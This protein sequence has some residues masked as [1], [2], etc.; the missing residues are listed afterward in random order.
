MHMKLFK[1]WVT[2]PEECLN[3]L[4]ECSTAHW[5]TTIIS[6]GDDTSGVMYTIRVGHE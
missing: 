2:R 4:V 3:N 1:P 5:K 6:C